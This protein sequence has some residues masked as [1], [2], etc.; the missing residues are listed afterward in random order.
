[1]WRQHRV[2]SSQASL[3]GTISRRLVPPSRRLTDRRREGSLWQPECLFGSSRTAHRRNV[4]PRRAELVTTM[5]LVSQGGE[6]RRAVEGNTPTSAMCCGRV[7]ASRASISLA[8]F[9]SSSEQILLPVLEH[10]ACAACVFRSGLRE[11]NAP[12]LFLGLADRR[13]AG[14]DGRDRVRGARSARQSSICFSA[15]FRRRAR[16]RA[17]PSRPVGESMMLDQG[18]NPVHE[19]PPRTENES[20]LSSLG[21]HFST[22]GRRRGPANDQ[23]ELGFGISSRSFEIENVLSLTSRRA[24]HRSDLKAHPTASACGTQQ[25]RKNV[26]MFSMSCDSVVMIMGLVAPAIDK[27]GR[28]GRFD[29]T[30]DQ[31]SCRWGRLAA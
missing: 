28:I 12:S 7:V 21:L 3:P 2:D 24:Q 1:M 6:Q 19:I 27:Q 29:Q 30:G 11:G 22:T 13:I 4:R 5:A 17:A 15:R 9:K 18:G 26:G 20:S 31:V 8:V 10:A 14:L 16:I 25:H 23:V